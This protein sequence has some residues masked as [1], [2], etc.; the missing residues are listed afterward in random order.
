ML[1]ESILLAGSLFIPDHVRSAVARAHF[2][3]T[4]DNDDSEGGDLVPHGLGSKRGWLPFE[5]V[6]WALAQPQPLQKSKSQA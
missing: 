5:H 6:Q 2:P 1:K 3:V 4:D